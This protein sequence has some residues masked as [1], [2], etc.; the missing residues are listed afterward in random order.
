ML[1]KMCPQGQLEK[2]KK[3]VSSIEPGSNSSY[4]CRRILKQVVERQDQSELLP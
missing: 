4:S 3:K 1:R 2:E